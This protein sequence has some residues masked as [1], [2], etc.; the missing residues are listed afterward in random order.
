VSNSGLPPVIT[1]D[2]LTKVFVTD[3]VDTHALEDVSLQIA[4][5]EY[6]SISGPSGCGKS[7]LLSILGLLDSPSTGSYALNGR[8]VSE[9]KAW[10]RAR[11]RNREI[12]FIFQSFNLIGDLSVFENVELPLTYRGMRPVER[13]QRVTDA[14]ERV[15]MAHR[16][17]HLPS[18][19]SGGQQQRVAVARAVAGEPVILLADE[20]TGNLDSKSGESVMELLRELYMNGATICMVTHDPRYARHAERHIHLFDGR[21]VSEAEAR[22]LELAAETLPLTLNSGAANPEPGLRNL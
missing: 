21:V 22:N 6:V 5:G 12:G 8:E 18:Q 9:L 17:K 14:L 10:E 20:P 7:T 3:E 11:V 13:R 4:R 16:A 19:L 15:G 1:L 2:Q